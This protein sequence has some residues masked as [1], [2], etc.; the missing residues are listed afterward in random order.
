[1]PDPTAGL[2]IAEAR[3]LLGQETVAERFRRAR[4]KALI[5]KLM[6]GSLDVGRPLLVEEVKKFSNDHVSMVL[7]MAAG[8]TL[9]EIAQKYGKHYE[10]LQRL[11]AHPYTEILLAEM[12]SAKMDA[13]LDPMTRI[14]NA[15]NEMVNTKLEIVR[16]P[17]TS[18]QLR[19]VVATDLLDRAGLT[20]P[21]RSEAKVEHTFSLPQ[22]MA[23]RLVAGLEESQ[24]VQPAS[25]DR[26]LQAPSQL[27]QGEVSSASEDL[28]PSSGQ[29]KESVGASPGAPAAAARVA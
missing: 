28:I 24:E 4:V 1:M 16:D 10:T 23:A 27:L 6:D 25:Y 26:Y 11:R 20:A 22:S 8:L 19:N 5:G 2:D 13:M 12:H 14:K 3:E 21:K 9:K 15:A 17:T 7:E 29:T 18:K